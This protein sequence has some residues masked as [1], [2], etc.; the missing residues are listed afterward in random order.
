LA[1]GLAGI[2]LPAGTGSDT[3]AE[4]VA[5][6]GSVGRAGAGGG[7]SGGSLIQSGDAAS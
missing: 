6:A 1:A 3:G 5:A 7:G 4:L 2:D